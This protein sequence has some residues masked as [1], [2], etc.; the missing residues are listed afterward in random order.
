MRPLHSQAKELDTATFGYDFRETSSS[1]HESVVKKVK[2]SD[3]SANF[4]HQGACSAHV[5][6]ACI[7]NVITVAPVK[8]LTNIMWVHCRCI[9]VRESI[10]R[11]QFD[12]FSASN[13]VAVPR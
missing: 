11:G 5:K 10:W 9:P 2:K 4:D 8:G 7:G 1:S 13:A 12:I 3:M 6:Q